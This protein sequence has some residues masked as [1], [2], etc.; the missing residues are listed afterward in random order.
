ML[1]PALFCC[2][3]LGACRPADTFHSSCAPVVDSGTEPSRWTV[4]N[5]SL[6][7]S[8]ITPLAG[9]VSLPG[10]PSHQSFAT[11][12]RHRAELV[13]FDESGS[14]AGRFGR[15]GRGPGDITP[16]DHYTAVS[17]TSRRRDWLTASGDTLHLLDGNA[18]LDFDAS[19]GRLMGRRPLPDQIAQGVSLFPRE[20]ERLRLANGGYLLDVTTL[21]A[22]PG[23]AKADD[24]RRFTIWQID[25][26]HASERFS[27]TLPLPPRTR[28]GAMTLRTHEA[29]P[30]WDV[31]GPCLVVV[32][33]G[34]PQLIVSKLDGSWRDTIS[35]H[36][37]LRAQ[38]A[39]EDDAALLR[40]M[41]G[42]MDPLPDP[43]LAARI[44]RIITA[45][46]GWVWL[47][48]AQPEGLAPR[49][50][51]LRVHI[52][53]GEQHLDTLPFFPSAFGPHGDMIG[54]DLDSLGVSW[55]R[56]ATPSRNGS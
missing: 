16:L 10:V 47:E 12:D 36:A 26:E 13:R 2:L 56:L 27:M 9:I 48:L 53:N 19:R 38:P 20:T 46:E 3:L 18:I 51:I 21:R 11:F 1:R 7:D 52:T 44:K 32:D 23:R 6:L 55:L 43:T 29:R 49:V 8:S 54:I 50:E 5:V 35:I 17:Y 39:N 45:P 22:T 24:Q 41:N 4:T 15:P 14:I 42:A 34:T 30:H 33:G 31:V 40:S 25:G 37:P 28:R